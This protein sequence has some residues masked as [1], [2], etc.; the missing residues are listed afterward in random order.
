MPS[1]QLPCTETHRGVAPVTLK[2]RFSNVNIPGFAFVTRASQD[3]AGNPSN[4]SINRKQV[5]ILS[6]KQVGL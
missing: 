5:I 3:Q 1:H 2:P 4:L 6:A